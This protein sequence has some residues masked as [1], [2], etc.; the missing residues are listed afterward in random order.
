M[1]S[2]TIKING[3]IIHYI[4]AQNIKGIKGSPDLFR[5]KCKH[6]TNDAG[7]S[8]TLVHKRS[9]GALVL[10]KKLLSNLT[11]VIR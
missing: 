3:K 2:V 1:L 7:N 5:Y 11:E 6:E 9:D 4:T 10:A 8:F